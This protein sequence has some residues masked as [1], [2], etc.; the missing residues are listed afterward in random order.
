MKRLNAECFLI[1][2][3]FSTEMPFA[4]QGFEHQT[5][6]GACELEDE[7]TQG[8]LIEHRTRFLSGHQ[9]FTSSNWIPHF[10]ALFCGQ[11]SD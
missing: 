7:E 10:S 6:T 9:P 11:R 3:C 5:A 8:L 4:S 1:C 2:L